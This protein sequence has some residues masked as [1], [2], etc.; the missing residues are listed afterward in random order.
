LI[1]NLIFS[2]LLGYFSAVSQMRRQGVKS[3]GFGKY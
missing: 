1:F 2:L 3:H